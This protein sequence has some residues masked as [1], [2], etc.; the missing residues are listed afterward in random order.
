MQLVTIHFII[1]ADPHIVILYYIFL[2]YSATQFSGCGLHK[3]SQKFH[4][5]QHKDVKLFVIFFFFKTRPNNTSERK[6]VLVKLV[7]I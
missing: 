7:L 5:D 3:R 6:S 2:T 1:E 4:V